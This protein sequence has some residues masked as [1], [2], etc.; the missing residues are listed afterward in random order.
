MLPRRCLDARRYRLS[1]HRLPAHHLREAS[2]WRQLQ[3]VEAASVS[4][5]GV[6]KYNIYGPPSIPKPAGR[7]GV[8]GAS[9]PPHAPV[10][11]GG[12]VAR[13]GLTSADR[14]SADGRPAEYLGGRSAERP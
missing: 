7:E 1:H 4:Q 9:A 2:R 14:S 3:V 5:L 12:T 13:S 11:A 6:I 8:P 10:T